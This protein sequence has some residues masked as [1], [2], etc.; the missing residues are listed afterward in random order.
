MI[1]REWSDWR[2][3]WFWWIQSVYV[4]EDARSGG[5]FKALFQHLRT[6]A[7]KDASVIGLRLYVERDNEQARNVYRKLGMS[8]TSYGMLEMYP[9]Q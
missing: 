9:L 7:M 4:H 1:T 8:D 3:G 5:V 2:N 6:E